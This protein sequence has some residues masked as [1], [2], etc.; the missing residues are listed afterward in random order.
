[1]MAGLAASLCTVP[2]YLY[3]THVCTHTLLATFSVHT[4]VHMHNYTHRL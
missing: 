2:A 1:M 4:N 3:P